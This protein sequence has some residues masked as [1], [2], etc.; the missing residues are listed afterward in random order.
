[1]RGVALV[2][3]VVTGLVLGGC[4]RDP[5]VT[6]YDEIRSGEWWISQQIDRVTG[7]ELPSA[8]VYE[9]ASNTN[10]DF[11]KPSSFQ[12]TCLDG[13]PV[14]RFA[15]AFKVGND[16]DTVLGYRFDDRPGHENVESRVLLGKQ[17]VVIEEKAALA[18]FMSELRGAQALYVRLRSMILGRTA[19]E[20]ALEGS[21]AA[22]DAA[23]AKCPM[24]PLPSQPQRR[25]SQKRPN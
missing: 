15:F 10:E 2:G 6:N 7:E 22:I 13:K 24:P 11:P 20:Y 9:Y 23:F 1:M 21:E 3:L 5:Y 14:V 16:K 25:T 18:Q 17:M 19:V 8:S 12:M 4:I